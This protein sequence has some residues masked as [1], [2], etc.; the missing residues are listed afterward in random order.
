MRIRI[1]GSLI[2]AVWLLTLLQASCSIDDPCGK[3]WKYKGGACVK[4]TTATKP[5]TTPAVD[6]TTDLEAGDDASE[7]AALTGLGNPCT[8]D[9]ECAGKDADYCAVNLITK[10]GM[11][12]IKC[13]DSAVTCPDTFTCC[14]LPASM[15][16]PTCLDQTNYQQAKGAG[17]CGT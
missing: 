12:T 11:C 13:A 1:A 3:G 10:K 17:A 9:P 15:G 2:C 16:G 7:K 4:P 5:T 8:T 6:A 14:K